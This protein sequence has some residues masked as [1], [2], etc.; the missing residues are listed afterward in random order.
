M[1]EIPQELR[2]GPFTVARAIELGLTPR[3][4]E[5]A[6]FA[7]P[8]PGVRTL[9][10]S[11]YTFL[12]RCRAAA[13]VLPPEAVFT[14]STALH[15]GGWLTPRTDSGRVMYAPHDPPAGT[16]LHVSVPL[17][18][19]RP[20]GRGITAHQWSPDPEDVI[21]IAGLAVSSPWR[22]WCDLGA[23]SASRTDLVILADALRRHHGI[24]R[25]ESRL[26]DWGSR[27]GAR[28]LQGAL[29]SSR[30]GVDSPME[31]R[32]RLL[33]VDAGLP[34]PL[35]NQWILDADGT[36]LHKPDLSW[37]QWRVAVD[38]DGHHHEQRD[39]DGDVREGRASNWRQRQDQS[40]RDL[41]TDD[42]WVFRVVTAFDV[43]G[44]PDLT[45]ERIRTILRRAGAPV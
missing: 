18:T 9:R 30:D 25:L 26:A 17:G 36:P 14:H 23:T 31:T 12:D 35:V 2:N 33:L 10:E 29:A 19:S 22:T 24:R 38:Y 43:L 37:P 16:P 20:H 13:L 40:R 21:T 41:L 28:T 45:A 5:G 15:L 32:L 42:G 7:T 8:R 44:R 4:L 6:R 39:D 1:R 27:R 11:P 34:E 3:V